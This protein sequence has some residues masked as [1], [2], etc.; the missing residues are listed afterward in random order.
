MQS[1]Y[2]IK[3]QICEVGKQIFDKGYCAANDGNI[4]VKVGDNEFYCTPTGV[5]KGN[6]TPDMIIKIDANGNKIDGKLN[7]SSE[8]KMHMRVYRERPD[9]R[10]VV[11]AH[12]PVATA[13]AAFAFIRRIAHGQSPMHADRS[14]IHHR[15]IDMGLN[16]KQAVATLYVI[17]AILGLS[18]VV[19][20]TSGEQ[21]AML[22]FLAL[23]IVGV[24][25]ARV[26][27]P[28]Q[29]EARLEEKDSTPEEPAK[30]EE[31]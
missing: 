10:S 16:Q 3:K 23:C 9:V 2:D 20:T 19:L 30:D 22:L 18:A 29:K 17:S 11:H 7:P 12:P 1:V 15:L 24:V 8:I 21:K 26:V 14:H 28:N 31:A 6:M 25:A 13:F 27:F 5:S 4:S